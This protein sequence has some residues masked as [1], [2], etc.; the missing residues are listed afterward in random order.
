MT[1]FE[2]IKCMNIYA[3]ARENIKRHASARGGIVYITSDEH[4]FLDFSEALDYELKW[5]RADAEVSDKKLTRYEKLMCMSP[6]EIDEFL[7]NLCE[8]IP[9]ETFNCESCVFNPICED[10]DTF[11][12]WLDEED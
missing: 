8:A 2:H 6:E 10:C 9:A 7:D 11:T 4:A 3:M 12:N 1:N 5:L